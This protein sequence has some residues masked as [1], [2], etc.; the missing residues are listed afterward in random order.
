MSSRKTERRGWKRWA[1]PFCFIATIVVACE[2]GNEGLDGEW[3]WEIDDGDYVEVQK[4]VIETDEAGE[5]D[6][7]SYSSRDED[8][9]FDITKLSGSCEVEKESDGSVRIVVKL[10]KAQR[11]DLYEGAGGSGEGDGEG[12]YDILPDMGD[13]E[14]K[15]VFDCTI[16][17]DEEQLECQRNGGEYYEFEKD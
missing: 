2:S 10:K 12:F 9:E 15:F 3:V 11:D 14:K 5:V 4:L 16:A 7:C 6:K 1:A 17:V 13:S 8:V